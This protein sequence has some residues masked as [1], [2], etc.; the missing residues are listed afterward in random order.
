MNPSQLIDAGSAVVA[1]QLTWGTS[2]NISAR[3]DQH[4]FVI[5]AS[6]ARLG[7]LTLEGIASCAIEQDHWDGSR[8]PSVETGMHRAVYACRPDVG[9][10]LHCS[11]FFTTL[12]ASSAIPV[13]PYATTDSVYYVGEV[14][15]VGFE[16]PGT[17]E[18]ADAVAAAIPPVDVLLLEHHGCVCVAAT[19]D[20]VV[21][22]AEAFEVL[23][24]M[25]V[26]EAQGFPLQRLAPGDVAR[27]RGQGYG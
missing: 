27:L 19:L 11:P 26:A 15:R 7:D 6:G 8:R 12:V 2:G 25:L 22:R 4:R 21:N 1:K 17:P 18:L 5:S 20:E 10:V 23:C 14:G 13:D 3:V 9:A 24:R 16:L